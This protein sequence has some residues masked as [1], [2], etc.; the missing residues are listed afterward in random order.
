MEKFNIDFD[1]LLI[2]AKTCMKLE[3]VCQVSF[4]N[5]LANEHYQNLTYHERKHM[6][7]LCDTANL[8]NIT[9]QHFYDR[10]NPETQFEVTTDFKG[11]IKKRDCYIHKGS[12]H[13]KYNKF[14]NEEHITDV[15]KITNNLL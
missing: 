3:N 12:Y 13:F 8:K 14:I 2:L 15:K 11:N 9:I 7:D 4:I 10:F 6:F 1:E 5:K